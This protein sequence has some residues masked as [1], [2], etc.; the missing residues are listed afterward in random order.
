M[1]TP[2]ST[3]KNYNKFYY[4]SNKEEILRKACEKIQCEFCHRIVIKNN[5]LSHY[6]SEICKRKS[7][8]VRDL[9]ERRNSYI[10]Y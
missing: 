1:E 10:D 6:K 4:E 2:N 3:R 5:L 7:V 9:E 8:L